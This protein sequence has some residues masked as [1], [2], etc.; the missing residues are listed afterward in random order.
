MADNLLKQLRN[1][2][3]MKFE[4]IV[5]ELLTVM[6]YGDGKVTKRT[7]VEGLDGVIKNR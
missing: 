4:E 1:V 7:N 3:W 5:V 6:G 2:H